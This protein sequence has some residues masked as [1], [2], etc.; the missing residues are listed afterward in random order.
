MN[1]IKKIMTN[2]PVNVRHIL[3]FLKTRGM[4]FFSAPVFDNG[5]V[6]GNGNNE[7]HFDYEKLKV[8]DEIICDY[9]NSKKDLTNKSKCDNINKK[10]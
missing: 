3:M 9:I 6:V 5:F 2:P 8:L 7:L 1:R 4:S 10:R